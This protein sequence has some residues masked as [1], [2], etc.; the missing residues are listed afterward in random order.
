[1]QKD[2]NRQLVYYI[3]SSLDGCIASNSGK[4]DLFCTQPAYLKQLTHLYPETFPTHFREPL[5]LS[6]N[7][8]NQRFD[9]VIMGRHT[10][11]PALQAGITNPY[12]HLRQY[13]ISQSL[14]SSNS[15]DSAITINS[16]PIELIQHLKAE[17]SE[18]DIWLCGGGNLAAQ[19]IDEIDELI[20]KLNPVIL[21]QGIPLFAGN[22]FQ[23]FQLYSSELYQGGVMLLRYKRG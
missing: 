2:W 3:A 8:K 20:I 7:L 19:L 4:T 5:G 11:E 17:T 14:Q 12:A 13:V 9:T 22:H 18:K 10:Y 6:P 16:T 1:M 23:A 15:V 21:G